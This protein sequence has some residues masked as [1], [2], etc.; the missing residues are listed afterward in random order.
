MRHQNEKIWAHLSSERG[1]GYLVRGAILGSSKLGEGGR[2]RA[3]PLSFGPIWT[4][5][6]GSPPPPFQ[7]QNNRLQ[8]TPLP[9]PT[10]PVV[11][12]RVG[13]KRLVTGSG[14]S[15]WKSRPKIDTVV[16]SIFL[17][18]PRAYYN[19]L[20]PC[21]GSKRK[22]TP[23][24]QFSSSVSILNSDLSSGGPEGDGEGRGIVLRDL[25]AEQVVRLR[26]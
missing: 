2:V 13:I 6:R 7:A 5:L 12:G 4:R 15:F 21:C 18:K 8:G 17:H 22:S 20:Q 1:G 23:S 26:R 10:A 25:L 19:T 11:E 9:P 24:R 3:H 14:T 16:A